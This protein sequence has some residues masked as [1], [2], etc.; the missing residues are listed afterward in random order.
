M[1]RYAE[2]PFLERLDR[3]IVVGDGATGSLFYARGVP[4]SDCF[5]HLNL[6]APAMVRQVH[7]DY[8]AAGARFLETNTF[9]GNAVQLGRH[10]LAEEGREINR[11]GAKLAKETARGE[12]YVAGSVGPIGKQELGQEGEALTLEDR[13]RIYFEQIQS[14]AEGGAD[15]LILETFLNLDDLLAAYRAARRACSLP[16]IAQMAFIRTNVTYEGVGVEGFARV[17]RNAGADVIGANCGHGTVGAISVSKELAS[18]DVPRISAFPNAGFPD[19][20]EGRYLYR[21]DADYFARRAAE[22]ADAGARLVGGCCGTG[23][24]EIRMLAKRLAGRVVAPVASPRRGSTVGRPAQPKPPPPVPITPFRPGPG[25]HFLDGWP[26]KKI[27]TVE[28]DPPRAGDYRKVIEGAKLCRE[29][30]A[31]AIS[32]ADNP[33]AIVRMSNL[34]LGHLVQSEA[35]IPVILHIAGRDR[36]LLGIRSDLMGAAALGL[37]TIFCITGDP[38]SVGDAAGATSVYDLNSFGLVSLV[39]A[40]N[41]GES[42]GAPPGG[43]KIG[44]AYNPNVKNLAVE[45]GRLRKKAAL[46]AQFVQTQA[47]YDAALA[48]KACE[49]VED[50][51]LPTLLGVMPFLNLKNAEF[52]AHEIPGVVVPERVLERVRRAKDGGAEGLAIS[53]E[54]IEETFDFAGGYYLLPPFNKAD[55]AVRLLGKIRAL[56][57]R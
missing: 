10:G 13:E 47:V 33:L 25:G 17:L 35:G 53:E 24:D 4:M 48:R 38:T 15:V 31:D 40:M 44:V 50:L 57:S 56:A 1:A 52:I 51:K 5:E 18:L 14:I 23:P 12:A 46:G 34:V 32:I 16:V 3:E 29:A 54:L 36:N 28:L 49:A 9:R 19:Y 7:A 2:T 6:T 8:L 55:L 20:V 41:K 37:Q 11:A 43:F 42:P 26:R 30:G 39:A 22:A 21:T 45:A 27:V